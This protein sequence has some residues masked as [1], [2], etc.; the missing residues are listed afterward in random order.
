MYRGFRLLSALFEAVLFGGALAVGCYVA[1]GSVVADGALA[2]TIAGVVGGLTLC[3]VAS[4]S[5][6]LTIRDGRP[7]P[8]SRFVLDVSIWIP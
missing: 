8:V 7:F 5:Y 6:L 3:V 2:L 1:M 4:V